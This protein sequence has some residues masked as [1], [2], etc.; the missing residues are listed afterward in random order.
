MNLRR[1]FGRSGNI[2]QIATTI[3]SGTL[4]EIDSRLNALEILHQDAREQ[5][6]R[7]GVAIYRV[8]LQELF[9]VRA[10]ISRKTA[11]SG[12]APPGTHHSATEQGRMKVRPSAAP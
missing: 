6:D 7:E 11:N 8:R 3:G 4:H 1:V 9:Q 12:H 10:Q 2:G 5:R